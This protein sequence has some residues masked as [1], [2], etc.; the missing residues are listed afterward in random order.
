MK[1]A[2]VTRMLRK[3]KLEGFGVFTHE[4][5]SRIT[6]NHPDANFL[7]VFDR[8]FDEEF[9]YGKNVTPFVVSPPARHPILLG[10]WYQSRL[11]AF[12]KKHKPDV[13]VS[14]DGAIPLNSH[15][16]SVS[17]IHDLNF[18][19]FPEDLPYFAR[20]YFRR[21]Y[22]R[23]AQYA[24]R[25]VTVS[26]FS[27][28][29]LAQTYKIDPGKVEVVYNG[30]DEKFHPLTEGQIHAA[31]E[32]F[33]GGKPY[34]LFVGSIHKRKN[35]PNMIRAY[36]LFRKEFAD[37]PRFVIAGARRWWDDEMEDAL[38]KS[39]FRD[40]ILFPGRISSEDL[41]LLT[42]G[43]TGLL[44]VSRFEGFGIP[45]IEAMKCG[46]PVITSG[47][48]SLPEI[49]GEAALFA[50]PGS[51]ESIAAAIRKLHKDDPLRKKMAEAGLK[52]AAFFSWDAS[53]EKLWK[54]ISHSMK[55]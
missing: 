10:Y 19:H 37:G 11:G 31:R 46:V 42:G 2:V 33:A 52:R 25:V 53:A 35:L 44:F 16:P 18:E 51:A 30:V 22:R 15:L 23:A 49:A 38:T 9:V 36:G 5:F 50:D 47:T 41:P 12:L 8:A 7:F 14:P 4:L 32:K 48:T 21:Y 43:A 1:I 6:R 45:V 29:D 20:T 17:V 28:Q 55:K 39:N 34:F 13:L 24:T 26:E 40:D 54:V 3:D 27:K